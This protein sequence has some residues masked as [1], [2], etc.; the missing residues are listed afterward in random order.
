M[1]GASA[2]NGLTARLRLTNAQFV[3]GALEAAPDASGPIAMAGLGVAK[4][5]PGV[6]NIPLVRRVAMG[7]SVLIGF[8]DDTGTGLS[9][10]RSS[11][12]SPPEAPLY[13]FST[14]MSLSPETPLGT[15][16]L[17]V[18]R[19]RRARGNIGPSQITPSWSPRLCRPAPWSSRWSGIRTRIS[20]STRSSRST[21][22]HS[23]CRRRSERLGRG[24]GEGARSRCRRAPS[25][26][27]KNDPAVSGVGRLDFDSNS[28]CIID[29][30]RQE[31]IVFRTRRR[32]GRYIVRVDAFSM[33]GQASAQWKVT[34]T[35]P[36]GD[37]VNPATWQAI[38]ADTRGVPRH[39]QPA[40]WRWISLFDNGLK[41]LPTRRRRTP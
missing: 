9:R 16:T 10:R 17:I 33:C 41:G 26:Y 38:D 31:N 3:P 11:I 5:Y 40:D 19:R 24:L 4:L 30:R 12:L 15:E 14:R 18:P 39:R 28:N 37:V 8:A 35:T 7:T 1:R 13:T 21:E 27:D 2:D 34:V 6:Q 32:A 36:G 22:R 25:G 23:P 20:T 29:G